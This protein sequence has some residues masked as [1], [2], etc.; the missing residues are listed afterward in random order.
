MAATTSIFHELR[1][2]SIPLVKVSGDADNAIFPLTIPS[3]IPPTIITIAIALNDYN[4]FSST[5]LSFNNGSFILVLTRHTS[6]YWNGYSQGK[7]GWFPGNLVVELLD[8]SSEDP[9]INIVNPSPQIDVLI[10]LACRVMGKL[11]RVGRHL[12]LRKHITIKTCARVLKAKS[13]PMNGDR[14]F[15]SIQV[16]INSCLFLVDGRK[17]R[18]AYNPTAKLLIWQ[19]LDL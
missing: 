9:L 2:V 15:S 5:H 6:G 11:E 19:S 3:N 18:H 7:R 14:L 13:L 17:L 16:Q 4:S 8:I 10:G 12:E 1:E